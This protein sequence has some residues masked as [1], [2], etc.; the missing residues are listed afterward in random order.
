VDETTGIDPQALRQALGC[1]ATGVT[2]VTTNTADGRPIGVTMN[3]FASVSLD[4]PLILFS[5]AR[6]SDQYDA[7]MSAQ[8]FAV[9]VLAE[10]QQ[11]LSNKQAMQD[12]KTLAE[13]T[14]DI[15]LTGAPLLH[16]AIAMF[17]CTVETR[18]DGGDHVIFLCRVLQAKCTGDAPPLLFH[19]SRYAKL[20][21]PAG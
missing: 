21:A 18:H 10:D 5:L 11:E 17:D 7:F 12:D 6:T 14:Y 16:G 1:F 4:P 15:G 9:N 8:N 13:S 2:V 3:S 20:A 19:R